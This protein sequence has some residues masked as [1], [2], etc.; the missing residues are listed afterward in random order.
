MRSNSSSTGTAAGVIMPT[1]I[2]NHIANVSAAYSSAR[3]PPF[4][5][6]IGIG[7]RQR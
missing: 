5:A 6:G 7:A 3:R 1:I 4:A 2:T